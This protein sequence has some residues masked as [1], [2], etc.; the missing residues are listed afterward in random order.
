MYRDSESF[1]LFVLAMCLLV[2]VAVAGMVMVGD[3][4]RNSGKLAAYNEYCKAEHNA[5]YD[6][7]DEQPYCINT[8]TVVRVEWIT[9]E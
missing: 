4:E 8:E 7:I 1:G 6:T 5:Y 2:L 9:G 3:I